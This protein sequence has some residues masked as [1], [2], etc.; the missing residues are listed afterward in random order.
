MALVY[1]ISAYRQP[2]QLARLVARLQQPTVRFLIHVDARVPIKPFLDAVPAG[3]NVGFVQ[4]RQRVYWKGFSQVRMMLALLR[5]ALA[6]PFSYAIYLSEADYPLRTNSVINA[7]FAQQPPELISYWKL[8]DR[9][10]WLH[11]LRYVYVHDTPWLNPRRSGLSHIL[12]RLYNR[13][14]K[15]LLPRRTVR[16]G[17]PPYGGSE[18]F[19]L[20]S[21]A[22][23]YLI[24]FVDRHPSWPRW[25]RFSDSPIEHFF[26]TILLNAP[27]CRQIIHYDAYQQWSQTLTTEE[28]ASSAEMLPEQAFHLRFIDWSGLAGSGPDKYRERPAVLDE[29]DLIALTTTNALFARKFDSIRSAT[30]LDQLDRWLDTN[31]EA[32]QLPRL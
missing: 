31:P 9:P 16:H 30:L 19:S 8:T 21:Q 15:Y 2:H 29:R 11:K 3:P 20:S 14:V 26:H 5:E 18:Y 6:H 13:S 32:S 10:R 27:F 4:D 22:V 24:D 23:D 7:F 28:K 1:L 17:L 12:F 25:Y